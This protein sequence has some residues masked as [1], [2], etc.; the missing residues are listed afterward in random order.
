KEAKH[1]SAHKYAVHLPFDGMLA[2]NPRPGPTWERAY[3]ITPNPQQ[4]TGEKHNTVEKYT[5]KT[6][7]DDDAT[8]AVPTDLKA[9][10]D[11][12][13]DRAALVQFLSEGEIVFDLKAGR[14]RSASLRI[15]KE[16]KG[17]QGEGSSYHYVRTYSEQYAGDR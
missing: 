1:G 8:I 5:C 14:L 6:E 17:H 9:P 15:D 3:Q 10:P 11:A 2:A 12:A 4:G 16:L 13:G 7:A